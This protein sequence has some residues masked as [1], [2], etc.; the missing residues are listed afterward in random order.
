MKQ[1][2]QILKWS[3]LLFF[4]ITIFALTIGQIIPIEFADWRD[5][6]F[7][8]DIILYGLPLAI[9]MTLGWTLKKNRLRKSNIK[10]TVITIFISIFMV[11]GSFFL[12]FV[13]GFGAW[14]NEEIIYRNINKSEVTINQ[15]RWDIG[16]FG[17]GDQRIVKL[18]P[19]LGIY[20]WVS[21]TD[22]S[23]ID[24]NEWILVKQQSRKP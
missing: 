16:A 23:K 12:M 3:T 24:N 19:I 1:L 8:Y 20:N 10:I 21:E 9:I 7:F 15:Q 5:M 4:A 2:Q 14:M 11:F 13:Y 17:Y 18:T 22:T 6:H